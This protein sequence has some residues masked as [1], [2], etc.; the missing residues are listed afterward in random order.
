MRQVKSGC[1]TYFDEYWTQPHL[2]FELPT[3][4]LLA[5]V[6]ARAMAWTWLG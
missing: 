6:G 5:K 4:T 3:M 2:E 1:N